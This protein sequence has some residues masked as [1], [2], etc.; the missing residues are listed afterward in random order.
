MELERAEKGIEGHR[1]RQTSHLLHDSCC[2]K[3]LV[4]SRRAD[5]KGKR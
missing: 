2:Q 4:P 3:V 1:L 5:G